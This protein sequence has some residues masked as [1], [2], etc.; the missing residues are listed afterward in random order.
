MKSI[1]IAVARDRQRH[2]DALLAFV[3]AVAID[4]ILGLV[5]AVRQRQER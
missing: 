3:H 4:E 1:A 5:D 2:R